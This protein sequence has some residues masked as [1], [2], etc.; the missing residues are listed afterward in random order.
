MSHPVVSVTVPV[1]NTSKYL[2]TC[3][4]SLRMQTLKDIEYILVDDGSTDDSGLIC[5]E[6]AR[7]DSRF[8]VIHQKNGGLA[9]ARQSG[10]MQARG[11]Y[12]IVCDS[13]DWVEPC[14]YEI[15]YLTAQKQDADIVTCR[16]YSE[17]GDGRS[18]KNQTVFKE[19]NGVVD[20]FDFLRRGAGSSWVKLIKRS[21]Y[22]K[23]DSEYESGINLSEDSLIIYKLLKGNP[24]I[25]QVP[26]YLYHYRRLFGGPSYTNSIK[27][28][29][30][31]QLDFTY[32]WLKNN[33]LE[34]QYKPVVHQRAIDLA[35]ACLRVDDLDAGY[36]KQFI[37]SELKWGEIICRQPTL[38]S[39][40]V[41]L[42]KMFPLCVAKTVLRV[43]Y[44]LVYK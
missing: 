6:Y 16:Y 39:M 13:D 14:I 22:V 40:M 2:R 18:L 29:H 21:L 8:R 43:A 32:N 17:Y 5:D 31:Y 1:Y 30:I 41:C 4:E 36:F 7:T 42:E 9:S 25:V 33:Y 12:V 20:N 3:L 28:T 11:D 35:F 23:T 27:M 19:R 15:L 38:K 37:S 24:K 44:P 26:D 34:L 10:L